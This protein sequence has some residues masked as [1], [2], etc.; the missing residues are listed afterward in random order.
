[1]GRDIKNALWNCASIRRQNRRRLKAVRPRH[2]S[3]Y[4]AVTALLADSLRPYLEYPTY[5]KGSGPAENMAGSFLNFAVRAAEEGG[6]LS[7]G[8]A[9]WNAGDSPVGVV[10]VKSYPPTA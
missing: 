7:S 9:D 4:P 8:E 3:L 6:S 1:M 10:P 2:L 5:H